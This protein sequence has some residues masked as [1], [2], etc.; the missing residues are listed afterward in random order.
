[1]VGLFAFPLAPTLFVRSFSEKDLTAS[2]ITYQMCDFLEPKWDVI[3]VCFFLLQDKL[4]KKHLFYK[5]N[6]T[7]HRQIWKQL[8]CK[9]AFETENKLVSAPL[10]SM[11]GDL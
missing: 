5:W 6:L 10:S 7:E 8:L 1:M 4:V 3:T 11:P 9:Y 2:G